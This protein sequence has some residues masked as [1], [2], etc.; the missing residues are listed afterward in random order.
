MRC[1][2]CATDNPADGRFCI[3]CG[4]ALVPLCLSCGAENVSTARYCAQCGTSLQVYDAA[5]HAKSPQALGAERRHLTVL[6]CELVG[7]SAFAAQMDPEDWRAALAA[8]HRVAG[9]AMRQFGGHVAKYLGNG[10]MAFFGYPEAHENDAERAVR[11]GLALLAAI[12]KLNESETHP[13]LSAR[14]GVDSG[15]VVVGTEQRK[16]LMF[17]AMC[18]IRGARAVVRRQRKPHDLW[19]HVPPH[20][21]LFHS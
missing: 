13:T 4:K 7:S 10:L 21:R 14:I 17:S 2:N 11:A 9:D 15:A 19:K 5:A 1:S 16:I 12:S 3:S 6:F 20:Y 8:Y 18:R